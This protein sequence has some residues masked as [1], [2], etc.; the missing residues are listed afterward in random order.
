MK[1]GEVIGSS[2]SQRMGATNR[3]SSWIRW[4]DRRNNDDEARYAYGKGNGEDENDEGTVQQYFARVHRNPIKNHPIAE[5][6]L[7]YRLV[8]IK[9]LY[10]RPFVTRR[11]RRVMT[12]ADEDWV[13]Q[14]MRI[15]VEE[16]KG[17]IGGL[18]TNGMAFNSNGDIFGGLNNREDELAES[19]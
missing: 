4:I 12:G 7:G 6:A 16:I 15:D 13:P 1:D 10:D 11:G 3:D 19:G 18:K 9:D 5:E 17:L 14:W 8:S 2:Y